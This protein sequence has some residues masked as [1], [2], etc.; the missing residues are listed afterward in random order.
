MQTELAIHIT[1]R[2]VC[3]RCWGPLIAV[4]DGPHELKVTCPEC[5]DG[6][7]FVTKSGVA[8]S[9]SEALGLAAEARHNLRNV[10]PNP[11]AGKSEAE[12]I[13]D[14]GY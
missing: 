9:E 11:L 6:Q 7:G 13:K 3:A 10:L 5:G 2:Y 8:R 12:I 14:L 1:D 4:T